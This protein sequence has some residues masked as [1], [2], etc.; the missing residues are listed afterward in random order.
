MSLRLSWPNLTWRPASSVE[1]TYHA[2][3]ST[4]TYTVDHDG[5]SWCL[6]VWHHGKPVAIAMNYADTASALMDF[7]DDH[8][9]QQKDGEAQ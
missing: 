1:Q 8:A 7:A 6:R 3:T 4:H 9:A 5:T 2:K